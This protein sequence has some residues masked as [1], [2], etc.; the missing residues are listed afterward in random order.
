MM[1]TT[2]LIAACVVI[3]ILMSDLRASAA[4]KEVQPPIAPPYA[5]DRKM[6][7]SDFV[8]ADWHDAARNRD[9]PA[10]IYFPSDAAGPFPVIIF[11]H[12]LG[13]TREGYEYLARQWA[14]NGYV[15]VHLQHIGSDDSAW[16]GKEQP[17]QT[18]RQAA[19]LQNSVDRPKD[20]QFAVEQLIEMNKSDAKL[21][22][23]L[24]LDNL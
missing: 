11:S 23:K 10:K 2:T 16:R 18:M 3:S 22:R 13:G 24:D 19:N 9:V 5:P 17:M 20:L 15:S 12:G 21:K 6:L 1:N 4:V 7:A 8:R 14:A